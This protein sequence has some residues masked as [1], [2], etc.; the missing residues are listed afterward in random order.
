MRARQYL[1]VGGRFFQVDPGRDT[2]AWSLYAY[3]G[4][5]PLVF[6]DRSGSSPEGVWGS[7]GLGA[8]SAVLGVASLTVPPLAVPAILVGVGSGAL[9]GGDYAVDRYSEKN[10]L[11]RGYELGAFRETR[12]VL[13]A[14]I[15]KNKKAIESA[16]QELKSLGADERILEASAQGEAPSQA[17]LAHQRGDIFSGR[18]PA[19]S[20]KEVERRRAR[21]KARLELARQNADDLN[22]KLEQLENVWKQIIRR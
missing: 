22:I 18:M 6:V 10:S 8:V 17:D 21:A 3:A 5:N 16:R 13:A 14:A 4:D 19:Y 15:I 20:K 12:A 11:E 7:L 9:T 1:P 2:T